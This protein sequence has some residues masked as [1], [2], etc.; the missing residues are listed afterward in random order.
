MANAGVKFLQPD[1]AKWGG[2]SVLWHWPRQC[3]GTR[4]WPHFM[5]SEVGQQASLAVSA[6]V[7][8]GSKCEMDVNEN[9]L[10]TDLCGEVSALLGVVYRF[11]LT[12]DCWPRRWQANWLRLRSN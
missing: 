10:R 1:V 2:V 8:D 9:L 3:Q 12:L 5:G 4:L 7:G 6:A 11:S